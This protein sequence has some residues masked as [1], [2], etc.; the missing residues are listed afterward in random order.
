MDNKKSIAYFDWY[1][2]NTGAEMAEQIKPCRGQLDKI[3]LIREIKC[4]IRGNQIG[5]QK[6]ELTYNRLHDMVKYLKYMGIEI[7][8]N[9]TS[10][11]LSFNHI[12]IVIITDGRAVSPFTT[13]KGYKIKVGDIFKNE[14]WVIKLPTFW[15]GDY[16]GN[17]QIDKV[18]YIRPY[19]RVKETP[20]SLED[21]LKDI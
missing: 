11:I 21:F 19:N 3:N 15:I 17:S 1:M 6:H 9:P 4:A 8:I 16:E 2:M 5:I 7:H 20:L 10:N 13:T 18:L 14:E 12:G